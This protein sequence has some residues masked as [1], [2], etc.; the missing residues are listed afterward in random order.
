MLLHMCKCGKLI[1][2]TIHLCEA[3]EATQKQRYIDYNRHRRNTDTAAFYVSKEWQQVRGLVLSMYDY[4]DVY[5]YYVLH[6]I[7]RADTV[8]HITELTEDWTQRLDLNNLIPL[9]SGTHNT[10]HTLYD[11]D[12]VTKAATQA[13]LRRLAAAGRDRVGVSKLFGG[14]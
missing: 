10:I 8:H 13:T 2:Q 5:A 1:P 4:I 9:A 6:E 7:R 3:C 11:R 14:G 12:P